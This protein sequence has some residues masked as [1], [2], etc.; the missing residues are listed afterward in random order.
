MK[1]A[2]RPTRH[3]EP[4]QLF[5]DMRTHPGPFRAIEMVHL[6]D[7]SRSYIGFGAHNKTWWISAAD[8]KRAVNEYGRDEVIE[9]VKQY[10]KKG[11]I[12]DRTALT[13]G[14]LLSRA[15]RKHLAKALTIKA[16]TRSRIHTW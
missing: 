10:T 15:G 4:L 16:Q 3:R 13:L 7:L 6:G 12:V 11:P 8:V 2:P 5:T 1:F 14:Y 9:A